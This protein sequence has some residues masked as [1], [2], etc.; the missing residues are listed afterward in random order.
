LSSWSDEVRRD[1]NNHT[2]SLYTHDWCHNRVSCWCFTRL[3]LC[4]RNH[5][6]TSWRRCEDHTRWSYVTSYAFDSKPAC[7]T[8]SDKIMTAT[9]LRSIIGFRI[10]LLNSRSRHLYP[11]LYCNSHWP[12]TQ[13]TAS[14]AADNG[15]PRWVQ[16]QSPDDIVSAWFSRLLTTFQFR[17]SFPT[18][19]FWLYFPR[20]VII[21]V[22][23]LAIEF[24]IW[25]S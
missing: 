20:I 8:A 3:K 23:D 13:Q 24:T 7:I 17:Q 5:Q 16:E 18:M 22:M 4:P 19:T 10:G 21:I 15:L 2:H 11:V 14:S 12:M 6:F 9:A 1:L 25:L